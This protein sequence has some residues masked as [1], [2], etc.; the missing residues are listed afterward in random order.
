MVGLCCCCM[1]DEDEQ[2]KNCTRLEEWIH[3]IWL[4]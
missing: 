1:L 3:G 2:Q 4:F